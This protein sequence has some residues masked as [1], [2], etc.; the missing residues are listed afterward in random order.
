MTELLALGVVLSSIIFYYAGRCDARNKYLRNNESKV[1]DILDL[2]EITPTKLIRKHD[3]G[4]TKGLVVIIGDLKIILG[5]AEQGMAIQYAEGVLHGLSESQL[6]R[7]RRIALAKVAEELSAHST[8]VL[9]EPREEI[10]NLLE[11][12]A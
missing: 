9:F 4:Y 1:D 2:A 8:K 6:F 5:D 3:G 12:S 7:A 11:T 10:A